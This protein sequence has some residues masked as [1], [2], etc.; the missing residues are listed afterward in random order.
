MHKITFILLGIGGLNWLLVGILERDIF[1]YIGGMDSWLA[2]I[3]YVLIGLSA[4]YELATH[5]KRCR[6]CKPDGRPAAMPQM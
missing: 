3:V 5:A 2:R 4:V 6:E 1:S